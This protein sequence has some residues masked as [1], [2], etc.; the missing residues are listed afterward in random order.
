MEHAVRNDN[1]GSGVWV[2]GVT[3]LAGW[4]KMGDSCSFYTCE[5]SEPETRKVAVNYWSPSRRAYF[6]SSGLIPLASLH[7]NVSFS[8]VGV[9]ATDKTFLPIINQR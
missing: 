8:E 9:S 6:A 5:F 3:T 4:T 2:G 7:R 1:L